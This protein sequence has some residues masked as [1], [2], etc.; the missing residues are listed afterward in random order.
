MSCHSS[1]LLCFY[2]SW[3]FELLGD[4]HRHHY[5][6]CEENWH[7]TWF[8][9]KH[10][11]APSA[12]CCLE[13][14]LRDQC[15]WNAAFQ[16]KNSTLPHWMLL[17]FFCRTGLK[18]SMDYCILHGVTESDKTERL[19]LSLSLSLQT[20]LFQDWHCSASCCEGIYPQPGTWGQVLVFLFH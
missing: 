14:K 19:L 3:H 8:V 4:I 2:H 16:W 1:V 10:V 17:W 11:L 13:E 20:V 12:V 15:I 7:F 9:H 5:S 6:K 18:N